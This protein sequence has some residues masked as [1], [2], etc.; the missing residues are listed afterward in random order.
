MI[1][2][3][4]DEAKEEG[5]EEGEEEKK[6]KTIAEL[7]EEAE[8]FEGYFTLY[9]DKKTGKTQ[10]LIKAD[11]VGE[12]FIYFA[13]INNSP[14]STGNFQFK[15]RYMGSSMISVQRH[16]ERIEFV[17]ENTNFYFDPDNAISK[18]SAANI[19]D[20]LL[21]TAKIVAEDE[22][23][24][25]ILI[26]SDK[27]FN[28]EAL[29]QITPAPNPNADPKTT[30]KL[31][32][33]D[34]GKSKVLNLRSYPKNTDVEVELVFSNASPT[35]FG[36]P[37]ITDPRNVSV[38]MMHSFIEAPDNGYKRRFDDARVGYFGEQV[39][40]LTSA[41]AAP[42][43]DQINRWHLVKQDPNAELSEPVVPILWWI[44]NTTPV[45]W[46]DLIRDA[47][48]EWN[49]AFEHAG[50]K[51]AVRVEIQPDDAEWDAGDIRYN[52]LRWTSSPVVPFGG[53]G[54]SFSDP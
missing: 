37:D 32:K 14:V 25:D 20:S 6:P 29:V 10:M 18:A 40:D 50:F 34:G 30:F 46:R 19:S 33:L 22:E 52:V 21:A 26:E 23:T 38:R 27:L 35:V 45:E 4:Q 42:Y 7:T 53:Y 13:Q 1:A 51:N 44:E 5:K 54:P 15:G 47:A 41:D 3:A 43:R 16:Y 24:G 36:G 12:E 11:Q 31:G 39:T 9:R 8:K 17:R 28:S 49:K 2:M 48:L